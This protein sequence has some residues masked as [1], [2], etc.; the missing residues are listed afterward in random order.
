MLEAVN[1][2]VDAVD[3]STLAVSWD[4]AP[5]EDN[6]A[7]F[8]VAVLRAE[9]PQG[10]YEAVSGELDPGAVFSFQDATVNV[11]SF[12]RRYFYR[13]RVTETATGD[14][15]LYGSPVASE[16]VSDGPAGQYLRV[17]PDLLALEARRRFRLVCAEFGSGPLLWLK[18]KT[19]GPRCS[20]WDGLKN[21]VRYSN[22]A[23]CY[24]TGFTGGFY[25]AL[26]MPAMTLPTAESNAL[27]PYMELQ[28]YD[29]VRWVPAFPRVAPK[30]VLVDRE[31]TRWSVMPV[32]V[33][34]KAG[35]ETRQMLQLRALTRDS[36]EYQVPV[37]WSGVSSPHHPHI[38]ATDT[39]SYADAV[40]ALGL[41]APPDNTVEGFPTDV[42]TPP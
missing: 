4:L 12:W 21:R 9:A 28:P 40:S 20:C 37:S 16:S 23:L 10:P 3:A 8:T 11:L 36:V 7:D 1:I 15:A 33:P 18:R 25:A 2:R 30:D 27:T 26:P 34:L 14:E 31:G 42:E 24:G 38:R 17:Q 41:D 35:A 22:C 5:T 19:L 39:E 6:T 29:Q 32:Q 13:L